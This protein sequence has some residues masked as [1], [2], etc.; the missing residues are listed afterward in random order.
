MKIL[1]LEGSPR[2]NGNT[3]KLVKTTTSWAQL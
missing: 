2:E 1:G 3:E